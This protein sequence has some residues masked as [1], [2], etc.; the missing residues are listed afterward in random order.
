MN[1]HIIL[2]RDIK[3]EL[4]AEHCLYYF[5]GNFYYPLFLPIKQKSRVTFLINKF[6]K[7]NAGMIE[8]D[9]AKPTYKTL[10]QLFEEQVEHY[11]MA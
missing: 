6:R 9:R 5:E 4:N 10:V 8:S 1:N 3:D 11:G 7:E 2:S